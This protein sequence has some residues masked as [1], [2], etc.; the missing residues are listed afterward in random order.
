MK[1]RSQMIL[2]ITLLLVLVGCNVAP[3]T[4]GEGTPNQSGSNESQTNVVSQNQ[5]G[6]GFYRPIL[7]Q[8]ETYQTSNSRGITLRLN[9]GLNIALFEKDLIRLSQESFPTSEYFIK[10]GQVLSSETVNDW[11]SRAS[12]ANLEEEVR[13][14]LAK[15]AE[16]SEVEFS[17]EEITA[18]IN[19]RR[20]TEGLNPPQSGS[21][22]D[23][24]PNYLN[25]ILELDFYHESDLNADIPAGISL[26]LAMNTVDYYTDEDYTR[27]EQDI[28]PEVALQQGQD[29]ANEIIWRMRQMEGLENLPIQIS[30]YEQSSRDDLGGGV[31][32]A[33]GESLNG[34]SSIDNWETLDEER[35]IFPLEGSNSAEGNAFANFKSEIESFFPNLSGVTGRAH[36]IDEQL[37]SLSISV[38]TQ[39]YG[40]QEIIS[41]TQ[42]LN[43]AALTY[44]P[45]A[46]DVEIIVESPGNIEAFL[47]KSQTETEY[48]SYVFD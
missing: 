5:L 33:I 36:Y 25:S 39:F 16:E 11:L 42:Y 19:K 23:R 35:L 7:T 45:M 26:G 21:G 13:E 24:V 38:M 40:E 44:L 8:D 37:V 10:E 4:P 29:M 9:S 47:K 30:I 2:L 15:E 28:S 32:V 22:D 48:F 14:E 43:Q 12:S 34:S 17:E 20:L 31:Y 41:F 27:F 46:L 18:E 1:K 6:D 3:E